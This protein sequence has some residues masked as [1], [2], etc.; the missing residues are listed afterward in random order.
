MDKEDIADLLEHKYRTLFNWLEQHDNMQWEIG[1]EGKWTTGQQVLHLLQSIKPLNTALSLPKFLLKYKYG[2]TNR[3]VRDYDSV[4]K[5]YQERLPEAKE[6]TFKGSQKMTP[7]K[8]QDKNYLITRLKVENKKLQHKVKK[9]TDKDLDNLI[10]PHPLMGKMPV[11]EII[12][13][14]AYHAEHHTKQLMEKY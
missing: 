2:V 7:P 1:P 9:W 10:L 5:R 8:L 13:W 6:A 12:M 3:D 14:S 4:I 11:R